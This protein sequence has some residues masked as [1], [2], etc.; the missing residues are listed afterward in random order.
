MYLQVCTQVTGHKVINSV[1]GRR[2]C[3]H[4]VASQTVQ[5]LSDALIMI[6]EEIPQDTI[7][8]LQEHVEAKKNY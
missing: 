7:C 3:V 8:H 4:Q 2:V 5:E 6:W 1:L